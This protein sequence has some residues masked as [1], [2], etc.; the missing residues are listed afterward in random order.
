M[1]ICAAG[2]AAP[3]RT[4][5]LPLLEDPYILAVQKGWT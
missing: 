3:R 2:E 4:V 5:E 1:V